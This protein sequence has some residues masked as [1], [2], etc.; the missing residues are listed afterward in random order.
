[1][2]ERERKIR[3]SLV[4][5][6]LLCERIVWFK[7]N[8]FFQEPPTASMEL[9]KKI[10]EASLERIADELLLP[11]PLFFNLRLCHPNFPVCG[12]P[13]II[14]G[15]EKKVIVE[16]KP[17]AKESQKYENLKRQLISYG[18]LVQEVMGGVWKLILYVKDEVEWESDYSHE[19]HKEALLDVRKLLQLSRS[20]EPPDVE[21]GGKCSYCY[22]KSVCASPRR[23]IFF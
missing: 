22:F 2:I 17:F 1:L 10:H 21:R 20:E 16:Y 7:L 3:L 13:D 15:K 11:D 4:R 5:D 19:L 6:L 8:L 12:A 14:S 18:W 9:S 23:L